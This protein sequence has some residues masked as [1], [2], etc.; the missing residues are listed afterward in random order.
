[1]SNVNNSEIIRKLRFLPREELA[2]LVIKVYSS[3][4]IKL[5]QAVK[6]VAQKN[7]HKTAN[8]ILKY[9]NSE[10]CISIISEYGDLS[11][12]YIKIIEILYDEYL[13]G[14]NPNLYFSQIIFPVWK[15]FSEVKTSLPSIIEDRSLD[16]SIEAEDKYKE[17][18]VS[19]ISKSDGVIEVLF[20]YQKRIDYI[21]PETS[22]PAYVYTL[23]E[24][25]IWM[26]KSLDALITKS[27]EYAVSSFINE[28]MEEYLSC[29]VR[30]FTLHK[31]VINSVLGTDTIKSGN[32][33][34]LN[35]D[36]DEIEGKIIRDKNL[37]AKREGRNTD[38]K[39]D[40]KSSFHKIDDI[41]DSKTGLN[42]NSQL[43]KIS[44]RAHLKKSDLRNWSL[45]M[46]NRIIDEMIDLKESDIDTYLKGFQLEDIEAL[47]E[48]KKSGKTIIRDIVVGI[49]KAKF[50]GITNISTK[51]SISELYTKLRNYF[52]FVFI[53]TCKTCG[54][55]YYI[56]SGTGE[57]GYVV[58]G[59]NNLTATCSS[60]GQIIE[61][62]PSHFECNCGESLEGNFD[63]NV[64]ALPT[65]QLVNLMNSIVDETGLNYKLDSNELLKFSNGD[66]EIIK[67]NY[68]YRYT[69]DE[70]PAFE[71][72][73]KLDDIEPSIA[74]AQLQNVKLMLKEKC[75]NYKDSNCRDCLIDRK[76]HCL[77]RVIAFFTQGD[78][79]AHSPV[80]FGDVSF[81]QDI[82]GSSELIVC[83]AK[84]YNGAP[85][86]SGGD[87]KYTMKN[88]GG[89]LNQAVE[90]IFDSRIVFIGILSGAD[91]DPRLKETLIS[92]VKLKGKKIVF[93][94]KMDLVR[95]LSAYE[96]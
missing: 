28:I 88:N 85:K 94:E 81:R 12:K 90:S 89:L 39:Y 23:E 74:K 20:K 42:V 27:S 37:M 92:L 7:V 2:E 47:R 53:P 18:V 80:E 35:P 59:G 33:V 91:L 34:N 21:D 41:I 70:L 83:L 16:L 9:C 57:D 38:E 19:D 61:D 6:K 60:C 17:F 84:S 25:I 29:R 73:A 58:F 63:E 24:G 22:E 4:D 68:K 36:P 40:R 50:E 87:R 43:G 82:A 79:H 8:Y 95:I 69:F 52:N 76:G 51:Y 44:I 62:I 1:M 96:W 93:I 64:I 26:V 48:V 32:Y 3:D 77:Q 65:D 66:F 54:S 30:R 31:N 14:R 46:I 49:N 55:N 67:I 5:K 10:K 71:D 15:E 11:D 75:Q 56:C 78:L 45:Q 86:A 72:I 13:Y